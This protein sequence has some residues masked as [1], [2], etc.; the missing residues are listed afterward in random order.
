MTS[1]VFSLLTYHITHGIMNHN[2]CAMGMFWYHKKEKI[3]TF[4]MVKQNWKSS[5]QFKRYSH[6]FVMPNHAQ[7]VPNC[8]IGQYSSISWYYEVLMSVLSIIHSG[9]SL[10]PFLP[11]FLFSFSGIS[12]FSTFPFQASISLFGNGSLPLLPF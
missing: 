4:P 9:N 11:H 1:S 7:L 8:A 10:L 2:T 5:K 6:F 12:P 3:H